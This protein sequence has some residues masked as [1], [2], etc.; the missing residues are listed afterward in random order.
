MAARV[1]AG[2]I[3][4]PAGPRREETG[5]PRRKRP[6]KDRETKE[7]D[8]G[9][10]KRS[11]DDAR[12]AGADLHRD[13]AA[14]PPEAMIRFVRAPDGVVTPDIRS[15]LPGRGVWVTARAEIVAEAAKKQAFSRRIEGQGRGVPDAAGDVDRLLRP[16]ACRSLAMANKAGAVVAGFAKVDDG[17]GE[18][19]VARSA[20]G[21]WTAAT[22]GERKLG[23]ALARRRR[24]PE[25]G[26]RRSIYSRSTPIGFGFGPHKCDTCGA[27]AGR[28]D[29]GFLGALPRASPP[30]GA[31]AHAGARKTTTASRPNEHRPTERCNR[32]GGSPRIGN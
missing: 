7:A 18:G 2:W 1:R 9:A 26:R 29:E 31:R 11:D 10:T 32:T 20:R 12:V 14:R 5:E 25:R 24:R 8:H 27:R 17:A 30:I 13:A 15:R 6:P 19:R 28:T 22:D 16:I 3:E 23:Q 21:A 4:A